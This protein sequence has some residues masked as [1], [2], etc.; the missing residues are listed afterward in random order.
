M[1]EFARRL[2]VTKQY[3]ITSMERALHTLIKSR[4]QCLVPILKS[5]VSS[6]IL[7]KLKSHFAIELESPLE[8]SL[9]PSQGHAGA[10]RVVSADGGFMLRCH[11]QAQIPG[12]NLR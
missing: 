8:N 12:E 5:R 9:D 3:V 4:P 6:L 1:P 2:K 10:A 7:R 11:E